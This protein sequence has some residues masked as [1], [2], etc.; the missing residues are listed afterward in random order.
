MALRRERGCKRGGD[1]LSPVGDAAAASDDPFS[2]SKEITSEDRSE[3]V[4]LCA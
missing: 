3:G 1:G 4:M 2:W